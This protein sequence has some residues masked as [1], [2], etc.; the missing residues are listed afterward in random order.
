[1]DLVYLS[2]ADIE[3]LGMSMKEVLSALDRG[4]AAK[5]RG[6]TE[7]PPKPG[8][9][10]RPDCFIHAMPAYVRELDV[11]GLKWVSGYPPNTAEGLPYISGLLVLNDCDT[12]VPLAVMDCVWITAMRTGASVG[13]SARYLARAGSDT[14]AIVGCGVQARTS[15]M[16]L[17]EELPALGEVRCYDLFP[18]AT[19]RF[20][21]DMVAMFPALRFVAC[22]SAP[23]A[24]RGADVVVTAIP[25]VVDPQPDLDAGMLEEG[26]LGVALD[27][28][29]AWTSAAMRECD[30]FCSDDVDQLLAT[31]E[32]GVYFGGIPAAIS[33][34]LGELA[35]GLKPGRESD[36]QR[37]FSMNMGI[38]VDDMV[39]AQVLYE[40]ALERGAGARLPL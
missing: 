4:F 8:I 20:I 16:A 39:T 3:D 36:H 17:V 32:H 38:A 34:D 7:M 27:Y 2:R 35:A 26:G 18:E 25:I 24:A 15:L 33:A 5:G 37:I 40:R 21:A 22:A 14:V 29:S 28:D 1:V 9:H 31:K 12:G 19:K 13:I 6:A 30:R 11:A 23:D 10:T